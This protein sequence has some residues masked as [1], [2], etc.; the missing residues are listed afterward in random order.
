MEENP[1]S[2]QSLTGKSTPVLLWKCF[3][4]LGLTLPL[5]A[6]PTRLFSIYTLPVFPGRIYLPHLE[7]E[8]QPLFKK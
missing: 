6:Q 3:R 1:T 4:P 8:S 7:K 2:I 5:F